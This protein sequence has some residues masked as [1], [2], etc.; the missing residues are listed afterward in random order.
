[1][2][3]IHREEI[4]ADGTW[5]TVGMSSNV[6]HVGSR[7]TNEVEFWFLDDPASNLA[8]QFCVLRTDDDI[9]A[10]ATYVSGTLDAGGY[11]VWHLV[12]RRV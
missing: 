8:R 3:K 6:L 12:T 5:H 10:D 9:P 2:A 11:F 1:M 4:P 7:R